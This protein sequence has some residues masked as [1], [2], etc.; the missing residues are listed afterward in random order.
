VKAIVS[1]T[2][3]HYVYGTQESVPNPAD[4]AGAI[5]TY[6]LP[7]V[8]GTSVTITT[9]MQWNQLQ[10]LVTSLSHNNDGYSFLG[11][12]WGFTTY[13]SDSI[14]LTG[15]SGKVTYVNPNTP[16]WQSDTEDVETWPYIDPAVVNV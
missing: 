7:G 13:Y 16:D 2:Y 12:I 10:A 6:T 9:D 15:P 5:V 4:S 1:Y 8:N 14:K 3:C 11:G